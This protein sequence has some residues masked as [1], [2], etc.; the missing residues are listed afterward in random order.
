MD[1]REIVLRRFREQRLSADPFRSPAEVVGWLGGM[2]AQEYAEAKWSIAERLGGATEA[3]LD[4]AFDRGEI[5]RTHVLRPTWHFVTPADIRWMLHLTG[6][7][8]HT[9]MAYYAGKSGLDETTLQRSTEIA[10]EAL[11]DGE[12]RLR[13]ELGEALSA[14]G[15]DP[16]DGQRLSLIAMHLELEALI[17]SGPRRGKQHT[18][19]LLTDRAPGALELSREEALAELTRRY[20]RSHGPA[21]RN[22]LCAW[23][24]LT[25]S[26]AE[27]G[28]ELVGDEISGVVDDEGTHWFAAADA[29]AAAPPKGGCFLIPMYDETVMGYRDLRITRAGDAPSANGRMERT[30]VID[31]LA[32]GSWKRVLH[33]RSATLEATLAAPLDRRQSKAL[34]D[35]AKRFARFLDMPVEVDAQIP[36]G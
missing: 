9:V 15:V 26:D 13:R 1:Q 24:T 18:Y 14:G 33:G 16:G 36:A 6:P 8:I 30:I 4:A 19:A 3:E 23:A 20:F 21:T 27:R 28:L 2:Q 31:G 35:A 34:D 7:R 11:A 17:C 25:V 12:P 29:S 32:V 5:L 10:R 22:D